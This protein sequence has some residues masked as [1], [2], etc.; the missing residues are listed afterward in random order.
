MA[1]VSI[2]RCILGS[3][4]SGMCNGTLAGSK[5][6][7]IVLA[8]LSCIIVVAY[9]SRIYLFFAGIITCIVLARP[10]CIYRVTG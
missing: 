1:W 3:D 5:K 10:S 8:L 2:P 4:E 6:A 7:K 9:I